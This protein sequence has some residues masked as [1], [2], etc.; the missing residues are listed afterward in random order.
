MT[1]RK[2]P[3]HS[4]ESF[5]VSHEHSTLQLLMG[6]CKLSS[7]QGRWV[8]SGDRNPCRNLL[9]GGPE[10][11]DKL[12][13]FQNETTIQFSRVISISASTAAGNLVQATRGFHSMRVAGFYS[14]AASL[15]GPVCSSKAPS[16]LEF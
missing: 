1:S 2:Y 7:A 6:A 8:F 10:M 13:A 16:D 4:F 14:F 3:R 12:N 15:R 5:H 9:F 11:L